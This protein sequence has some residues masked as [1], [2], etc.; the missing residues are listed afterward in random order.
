MWEVGFNLFIPHLD[1]PCDRMGLIQERLEQEESLADT[2]EQEKLQTLPGYGKESNSTGSAPSRQ[3]MEGPP[4]DTMMD[5]TWEQVNR[6][7][8]N[9]GSTG[10]PDDDEDVPD[11]HSVANSDDDL[12]F[13]DTFATEEDATL[14]DDP[15]DESD[16]EDVEDTTFHRRDRAFQNVPKANSLEFPFIVVVDSSGIHHLPFVT[17]SCRGSGQTISETVAVGLLPSSFQEVKTVFTTACLDNYRFANLECKTSAY[18]Y[19]QMLKRR[20][21]PANPMAAPNRYAEFRRASREWRHLKKLKLHGFVHPD[22]TPGI[23]DLALFCPA[24]PQAGVNMAGD[25]IDPADRYVLSQTSVAL[26]DALR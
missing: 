23:G 4:P 6:F 14:V 13:G 17:C 2:A 24:C 20:T 22:K 25:S 3:D 26:V 11:L 16:W 15:G 8:Q 12:A 21:N 7:K 19:Y 9:Q 1:G 18:Q 10:E 5:D